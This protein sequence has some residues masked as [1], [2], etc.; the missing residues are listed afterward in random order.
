MLKKHMVPLSKGGQTV[1]H[2]GKGSAQAG[3][4]DRKQ[5]RQL[6]SPLSTI[7]DYSKASSFPPVPGPVPGF[8]T[9]TDG[10]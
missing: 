5:I 6:G 3:M 7:N 8:D 2:S 9:D 4:P 1:K 10:M